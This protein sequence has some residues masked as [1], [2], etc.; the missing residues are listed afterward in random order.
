MKKDIVYN[1]VDGELK[2]Q[3]IRWTPKPIGYIP[4]EKKCVAE[5]INYMEYHLNKA[6]N[7]V[8]HLREAEALAE[9]RKVTALGVRTMMVHGCPERKTPTDNIDE[10]GT[11]IN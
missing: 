7:S 4:D 2:Y 9:I 10:H 3:E 1:R 6:K 11:K 8:Y 5:W